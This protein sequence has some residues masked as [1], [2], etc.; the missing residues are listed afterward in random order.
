MS[1]SE[2]LWCDMWHQ[3]Q[4]PIHSLS[5]LPALLA[6]PPPVLRQALNL[7]PHAAAPSPSFTFPLLS[8]STSPLTP[9]FSPSSASP[10]AAVTSGLE[11]A[12][13]FA[14]ALRTRQ[15]FKQHIKATIRH[16]LLN[17]RSFS[18]STLT[19]KK[20]LDYLRAATCLTALRFWP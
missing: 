5:L 13:F 20:P 15:T 11:L 17:A 19:W 2:T 4:R 3:T 7:D 10:L 14:A 1:W 6:S 9:S 16:H 18:Q 8:P 12:A